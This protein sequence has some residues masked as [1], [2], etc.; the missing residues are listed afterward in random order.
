[1]T[2]LVT[3]T[4]YS[5]LESNLPLAF[6]RI[7]ALV[8]DAASSPHTK[9]VYGRALDE[10]LTWYQLEQPGRLSRAVVQQYR[11]TVLEARSL[12]PSSI[13]V[14]LAA[15]RKL[16]AEAAANGLLDIQTAHAIRSV[17]GAPING[18]RMGKWLSRA[19]AQELLDAPGMDTLKG[20]RD[21]AM[22][23]VLLGAG[24]RRGEVAALTVEH[25]QQRDCRW[26]IV[27]LL[28]KH[29]RV[30]SVAIA[31]WIKSAIDRWTEAAGI[32]EGR[33]FRRMNRH[34]K[35]TGASL[36]DEAVYV[37]LAGYAP[38][39]RLAVTPH[40]MRRTFAQLARKAHSSLEQIQMSLG[41]SSVQTTERYLGTRLDL[42]DSPSDRIQLH[43]PS[44]PVVVAE[45]VAI[46]P[47]AV[48]APVVVT[49]PLA[50]PESI[51]PAK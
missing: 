47:F 15:L 45:L 27:D 40:G 29:G 19:Q 26:V 33:L 32:T 4:D 50:V 10:F 43:L 30:R 21:T 14:K 28:G 38:R 7:R 41:H 39:V 1:M 18:G 44:E 42:A 25:I 34:G 12:A 2:H 3:I 17:K 8:L 22:L 31:S 5:Y 6:D 16:A 20:L 36:T 37:I 24:L 48:A 11:T 9:A 46:P 35:I 49:E 13:N 23:A 51:V